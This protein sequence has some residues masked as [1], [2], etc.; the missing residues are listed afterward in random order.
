MFL[1]QL[2][3][4]FSTWSGVPYTSMITVLG[5]VLG[6]Y[7]ESLGRLGVALEIWS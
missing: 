2:L 3:K 5:V 1:G 6:L 7:Y 4:Q